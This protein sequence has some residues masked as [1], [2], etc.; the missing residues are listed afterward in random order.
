VHATLL[1]EALNNSVT[2]AGH[3]VAVFL[4]TR[5]LVK[6]EGWEQGFTSGLLRSL[7]ALPLVSLGMLEPLAALRG[8]DFDA[9][10]N[11]F[12]ELLIMQAVSGAGTGNLR[13]IY[14]ILVGQPCDPTDPRC[15]YSERWV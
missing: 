12:K 8:E 10:D 3:R 5:S 13:R 15:Q 6:G 2:P 14:P 7:V 4:D 1:Y 11:L 9:A